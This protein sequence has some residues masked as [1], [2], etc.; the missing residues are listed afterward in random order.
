M[1]L[2]IKTQDLLAIA[3]AEIPMLQR[4]HKTGYLLQSERQRRIQVDQMLKYHRENPPQTPNYSE[5]IDR[6]CKHGAALLEAQAQSKSERFQS[7]LSFTDL[8]RSDPSRFN[9]TNEFT[10]PLLCG[11]PEPIENP[12]EV[13]DFL[14]GANCSY[15]PLY[16]KEYESYH[17][18]SSSTKQELQREQVTNT[19]KLHFDI[20]DEQDRA[21]KLVEQLSSLLP[22][23]AQH[24]FDATDR[25]QMTASAC[26]RKI[27]EDIVH[28]TEEQ[29]MESVKPELENLII[30][31]LI[32]FISHGQSLHEIE[33][34]VRDYFISTRTESIH[35]KYSLFKPSDTSSVA[36]AYN[37]ILGWIYS[38]DIGHETIQTLKLYGLIDDPI[39]Q[40][41]FANAVAE[42]IMDLS[43]DIN[44]E[45]QYRGYVPNR[46]SSYTLNL[47]SNPWK[48]P[49]TIKNLFTDP[50]F[51]F[52]NFDRVKHYIKQKVLERAKDASATDR[53]ALQNIYKAFELAFVPR[54]KR[55]FTS[56]EFPVAS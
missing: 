41:A 29:I 10:N 30:S 8:A 47:F 52:L 33:E 18:S 56:V 16:Y 7:L 46:I 42:D 26:N 36:Y 12:F 15:S 44:R 5:H 25:F 50:A 27:P 20:P 40:D 24:G 32:W 3:K 22:I 14:L 34:E 48:S 28:L 35:S 55:F 37:T 13:A 19:L 1:S 31:L 9:L 17:R 54:F 45:Y 49:N 43:L 2:S 21:S 11:D 23:Y 38:D 53:G 4:K 51:S 39:L 6:Q